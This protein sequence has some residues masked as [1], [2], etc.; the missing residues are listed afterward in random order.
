MRW[1][2]WLAACLLALTTPAA[3]A[4]QASEIRQ[5]LAEHFDEHLDEWVA[6]LRSQLPHDLGQGLRM[7][8]ID[9]DGQLLVVLLEV[10]EDFEAQFTSEDVARPAVEGFCRDGGAVYLFEAGLRLR[11]DTRAPGGERRT[12]LVVDRCPLA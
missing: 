4:P 8:A 7:V 5:Y 10:P 3:S 11:V 9:R 6:S 2:P 1:C 12:G